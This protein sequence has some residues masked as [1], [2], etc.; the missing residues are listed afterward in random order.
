MKAAK[1]RAIQDKG[2][3]P[4]EEGEKWLLTT[5][6]CH[7]LLNDRAEYRRKLVAHETKVEEFKMV[8]RGNKTLPGDLVCDLMTDTMAHR[9]LRDDETGLGGKNLRQELLKKESEVG[10]VAHVIMAAN[11]FK[12]KGRAYGNSAA[13]RR[14]K[15]KKEKE[16]VPRYGYPTFTYLESSS[17]HNKTCAVGGEKDIKVVQDD[18]VVQEDI[19]N[20][21]DN[22]GKV[23]INMSSEIE[24]LKEDIEHQEVEGITNVTAKTSE[25][26][27]HHQVL[28]HFKQVAHKGLSQKKLRDCRLRL[29]SFSNITPP[30]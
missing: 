8:R 18:M 24:G 30:Y 4:L 13:Q 10:D 27:H 17:E 15:K 5:K 23:Q 3:V 6:A 1:E 29:L 11:R 25:D 12:N 7:D 16:D 20:E 14:A 22:K 26:R 28:N 9:L 19:V 21:E 2:G